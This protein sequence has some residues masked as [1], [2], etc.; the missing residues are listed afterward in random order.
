MSSALAKFRK[1]NK[2]GDIKK[3]A[4]KVSD[5]KKDTL[6][7]LKHLRTVLENYETAEAKKFFEEN[8][9]H[10]YYIFFDNFVI[11]EAD[12]KQ[13]ANKSHREELDNIL[14]IFEKILL[15]LPELVHKRW[16]FHSIG[17]I[18]KKLLHPGNGLKLRRDGMR[19]F[20]IWYQILQDNASDE[21]HQIFLQLV[22]GLGKG[23]QQDILYGK[24]ANTPDIRASSTSLSSSSYGGIIAAGEITPILPVPGEKQPD[25][26]TKFFFDA[27]LQ[28]M[29]SE[30]IKI[31]WMNK[32][33]REICFVFLFN[34]FKHSYLKWL[35]PDF[36]KTRTIYDPVLDL[37]CV[38]V[39]ADTLSTDEPENVSECRDSFIRWLTTFTITSNKKPEGEVLKGISCSALAEGDEDDVKTKK[40]V[41]ESREENQDQAPGSNTSTLSASSQIFEKDSPNSSFCNE[42]H[43]TSEYEIVRSVMYSTR[44]NI[45]I[46]HEIFRQALLFSFKHGGAIRRVIAVYKDWFQNDSDNKPVFMMEPSDSGLPLGLLP[47]LSHSLSDILEEDGSTDSMESAPNSIPLQMSR[48]S[49]DL[50]T[51]LRN[52][53]YLGAIQDLADGGDLTQYDIRAG[54]QKLIQICVTNAANIFLLQADS[55]S[56]LQEQ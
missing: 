49:G 42:E 21:C 5:P 25:N 39:P 54:Q 30:V 35:L 28:F 16:M 13:R 53:S 36:D 50:K 14:N 43:S 34:K 23:E 26:I 19:L 33:M 1:S 10:I 15:L 8:Y 55:D 48:D 29:V 24:T 7:R 37:P 56:A 44:E 2:D 4:Q 3:A 20:L 47:D 12:L 17:R 22:P 45:N 18:M 40:D 6:T 46:V 51:W 11:V 32:D 31:E 27:L 9:S 38:R 41:S 52:A